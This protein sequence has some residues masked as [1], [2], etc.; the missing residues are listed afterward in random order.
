MAAYMWD[1]NPAMHIYPQPD[2]TLLIK[3]QYHRLPLVGASFSKAVGG[4]VVRGEGAYYFEKR[5]ASEDLSVNG[6]KEK[7]MLIILS[8]TIIT[9][10]V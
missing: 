6:V 7:I 10:L 3:P 8:A 5:F 4:A 1:D 9:G 2:T